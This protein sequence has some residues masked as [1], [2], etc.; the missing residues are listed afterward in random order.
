MDTDDLTKIYIAALKGEP[1]PIGTP[2]SKEAYDDIKA[3][4]DAD[5]NAEWGIPGE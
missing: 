2:E 1:D 4:I 5:P 3:E